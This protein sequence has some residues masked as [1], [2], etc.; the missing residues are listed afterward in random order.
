MICT[1]RQELCLTIS[2]NVSPYKKRTGG[3]TI[4]SQKKS[5]QE[6]FC[7]SPHII[8]RNLMR[9]AIRANA[10]EPIFC[11]TRT[12]RKRAKNPLDPALI[13]GKIRG[14]SGFALRY[15]QKVKTGNFVVFKVRTAGGRTTKPK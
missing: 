1:I 9:T 12:A 13:R 7:V 8:P 6:I 3:S 15:G 11:A 2:V 14:S 10:R 4:Y 5:P